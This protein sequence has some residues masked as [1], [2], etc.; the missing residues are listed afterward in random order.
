MDTQY[1]IDKILNATGVNAALAWHAFST[2]ASDAHSV[3]IE[4]HHVV[5]AHLKR[6]LKAAQKTKPIVLWISDDGKKRVDGYPM[7]NNKIGLTVKTWPAA[8]DRTDALH[9]LGG[10]AGSSDV[11]KTSEIS[12]W[13]DA[14]V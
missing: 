6:E 3:I 1:H 14:N 5:S 12:A 4:V 13:I 11:V 9:L 8:W 2:E 10:A 7:G